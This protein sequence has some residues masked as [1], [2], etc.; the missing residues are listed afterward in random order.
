MRL[1]MCGDV[2][3]RSGRDAVARHVPQLRR[4]LA[5]D[6]VIVNGENAAHGFGITDK[7]CAELYE[8]GV[9]VITTGNHVWDRR[10]IMSY[11]GSDPRLL[12]PLNY[13]PRQPGNGHGVYALPDGR[14]V[15]VVNAMARLFMDAIDDP[16]AAVDHLLAAHGLPE[17][18]AIVVDFHGEATS[19]KM[20][21]GHF[22]D[23][24]V[25]LVVGTHS[26]VPT[27][28]HRILTKGTGYITDVGM[29]GD[30]DSVI[31][32]KKEGSVAR[33]VTKLPGERLEVA[34]GEATLCAVA[35]ETDDVTG[36][37]REIVPVRLGG[38]LAQHWP[39]F[40][41]AEVPAK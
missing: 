22:C 35:V 10:E 34:E 40:S 2:V 39:R 38:G 18:A 26:H 4:E 30:Y 5:L 16:F 24:R 20:S 12:R 9:D 6:F 11:I 17:H 19:E 31:G 25:S 8:C 13:P 7:I 23:G 37:A 29:C 14:S 28:D 36:L 3:G 41:R 27:A 33:F 15:L 21:M 32:M 1:L